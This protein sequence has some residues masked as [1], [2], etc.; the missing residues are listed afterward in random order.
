[1]ESSALSKASAYSRFIVLTVEFF[2][3]LNEDIYINGVSLDSRNQ[4]NLGKTE[5][6]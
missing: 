6:H 5:P 3:S 1:M 2:Q 4:K